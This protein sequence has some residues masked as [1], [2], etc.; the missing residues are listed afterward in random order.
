MGRLTNKVIVVTGGSGL[1]GSAILN[2]L[3][4]EDAIA[5]N[6]EINVGDGLEDRNFNCDVTK[7]ES[8]QQ[9]ID[10]ILPSYVQWSS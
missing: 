3:D 4:Q 1:I 5:I 9:L 2:Y 6:A 10:K 8:V 7:E